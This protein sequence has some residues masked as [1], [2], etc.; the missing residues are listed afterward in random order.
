S[1]SRASTNSNRTACCTRGSRLTLGFISPRTASEWGYASAV[2]HPHPPTVTV[3]YGQ[4]E[5]ALLRVSKLA[6][7]DIGLLKMGVYLHTSQ[8]RSLEDLRHQVTA[9]QLR[10]A[11][12]VLGTADK[13]LRSRPA[14]YRSAISRYYYSMYHAMRA[15]VY[16]AHGGDDHQKH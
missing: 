8:A 5:A 6:K 16:F 15:V 7:R 14:Q 12:E 9:D 1:L 13:L 10:L 2:A 4:H 11:K 3:S